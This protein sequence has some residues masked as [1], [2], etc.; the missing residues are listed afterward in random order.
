MKNVLRVFLSGVLSIALAGAA[1]AQAVGGGGAGAGGAVSQG[2]AAGSGPWIITPWIGGAVNSATNGTYFNLL[3]GN[4]VNASG[5]PIFVQLT[6]GA[7]SLGTVGLNA[8]SNLVGK[9]GIDQTTPG[10]TNAFALVPLTNAQGGNLTPVVSGA[11]ET[12]HV[13][14]ASAGNLYSAYA[15]STNS[16][17]SGFF[18]CINAT[19]I[20]A[21]AIT[22]IDFVAMGPGPATVGIS[23]S[24][25]PPGAYS[26]GI[27]CAETVATTPFTYT[28][29]ASVLAYHGLVD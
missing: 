15:T 8:G 19:S 11:L 29:P 22:P 5:N 24:P 2:T 10:T 16:G 3:Q 26:T 27:T 13:F 25:G 7:A 4:A 28:A 17:V 9:V 21:G 6:A 14:K 12:N 18:V 23:Y 1:F 20:S